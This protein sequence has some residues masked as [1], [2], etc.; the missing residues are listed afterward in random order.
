M[1]PEDECV[2]A[3]LI[4]LERAIVT[5]GDAACSQVAVIC[6]QQVERGFCNGQLN[7]IWLC[8]QKLVGKMAT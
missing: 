1:S 7:L 6:V 2:A 5:F 8:C 3:R 4:R